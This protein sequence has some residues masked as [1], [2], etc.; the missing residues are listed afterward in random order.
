MRRSMK[1]PDWS[2]LMSYLLVNLKNAEDNLRLIHMHESYIREARIHLLDAQRDLD[3]LI[4]WTEKN[5]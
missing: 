2:S 1:K 4:E 5:E 3:A